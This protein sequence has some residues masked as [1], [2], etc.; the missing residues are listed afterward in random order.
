MHINNSKIKIMSRVWYVFM[1]GSDTTLQSNYVRLRVKHD[2][3]CG[4]EICAIYIKN[5]GLHPTEPFSD[6]ILTYI[7]DAVLTGKMQPSLPY[8]TKKYVY[9]R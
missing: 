3:L 8:N 9:L 2:C 5:S 6:N 7:N 1:G 4:T